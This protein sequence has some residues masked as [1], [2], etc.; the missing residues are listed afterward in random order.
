MFTARNELNLEIKYITSFRV[1]NRKEFQ[2][3]NRKNNDVCSSKCSVD[4]FT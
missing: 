2:L 4:L 3:I 1:L